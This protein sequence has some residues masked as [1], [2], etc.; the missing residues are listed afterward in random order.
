[1]TQRWQQELHTENSK[2][3]LEEKL[4]EYSKKQQQR[5][6]NREVCLDF[7]QERIRQL[8]NHN[9]FLALFVYMLDNAC[10]EEIRGLDCR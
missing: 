2:N 4:Q 9:Q 6:H 1:M 7:E 8:E 3:K 10:A 5:C